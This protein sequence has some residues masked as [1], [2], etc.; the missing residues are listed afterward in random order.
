M[1]DAERLRLYAQSVVSDHRALS[2]SLVEAESSSRHWENEAKESIEKMAQVEA[3]RDVARH[4]ALMTRMDADAAGNVG[5]QVESELA[6]VQNALAISEEARRKA[7]SEATQLEVDQTSI[8]LELGMAKDEVFSIR[9][10]AFKEKKA[11]EE[12]YKEGF[13]VIFNYGYGCCAFAHNIYGS[14][15]EVPDGMEPLSL[16]FF[17]NPRCP[18]SAI[19]AEAATGKV[20]PSNELARVTEESGK[21]HVP[22]DK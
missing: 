5:T 22:G 11:L 10:K 4:D 15:P 21:P 13:D 18:P 3:E 17:I 9:T 20:G 12:V 7:G 8:L 14:Q 1:R 6:R 2:A 19:P 16:E